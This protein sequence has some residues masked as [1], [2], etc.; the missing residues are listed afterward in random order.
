M[1]ETAKQKRLRL[2]KV[3]QISEGHDVSN[4]NSLDDAVHFFD[5]PVAKENKPKAKNKT[6]KVK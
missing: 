5:K 4:V 1:K 6:K 3:R 2:W